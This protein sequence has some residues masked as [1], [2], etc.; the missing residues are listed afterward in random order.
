MEEMMNL[1]GDEPDL[2]LLSNSFPTGTPRV[3]NRDGH[4]LLIL[5]SDEPRDDAAVLAD[6]TKVL[7][8]MVGIMLKD[9]PNFHRPEIKGMTKQNA[10]GSLSHYVNMS[11]KMEARAS[12]SA[13]YRLIGPDGKEIE[14]EKDK[15]PTDD[16][17]VFQLARDNEPFCRA[18]DIYGSSL[19][20]DW[21]NLY[22]VL[23]VMREAYGNLAG[24]KSKNFVPAKDID[25]FKA[26]AESL[27]AIGL[28]ARHGKLK[29]VVQEARI[30]LEKSQEMFRKLFHAWI[31]DI[32]KTS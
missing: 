16:Q 22:K 2:Q 32:R 9:R 19:E 5:E 25:D 12:M 21:I 11:V 6:G 26:T 30:T 24:L 1:G 10:D 7:A 14:K 13:E 23:D 31:E 17:I 28:K 4:Y 15:G 20:H 3:E 29:G 18:L 8:R 27:P